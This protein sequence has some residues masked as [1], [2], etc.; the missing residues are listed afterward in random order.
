MDEDIWYIELL[1]R[2]TN[3]VEHSALDIGGEL[4]SQHLSRSSF[5]PFSGVR[6]FIFQLCSTIVILGL[7]LTCGAL[8]SYAGENPQTDSGAKFSRS[9]R[10]QALLI[11]VSKY[12]FKQDDPPDLHSLAD[13]EA[14]K[15]VLVSK[16]KFP[17]SDITILSKPNETKHQAILDAFKALIDKTQKGDIVYVHYSGHGSAWPDP[18]RRK[19]TALSQAIVPTDYDSKRLPDCNQITDLELNHFIRD[20]SKKQPELI[21]C[22]F[23]CCYAG[24]NTRSRFRC[25]GFPYVGAA[26]AVPANATTPPVTPAA[27]SVTA[28]TASAATPDAPIVASKLG[29]VVILYACRFNQRAW[30]TDGDHNEEMGIFSYGLSKALLASTP[31]TTYRDLLERVAEVMAERDNSGQI[32]QIEGKADNLIL[33][34]TAIPSDAA[35]EVT[36]TATGLTLAAGTLEGMSV[37]SKFSLFQPAAEDFSKPLAVAEIAQTSLSS[38]QLKI[39]QGNK[40]ECDKLQRLRALETQHQ[41]KGAALEVLVACKD[42]ATTDDVAQKLKTN[43][44]FDVVSGTSDDASAAHWQVKIEGET[45]KLTAVR[46]NGIQIFPPLTADSGSNQTFNNLKERLESEIRWRY[47][48][49]LENKNQNSSVSVKIRAVPVTVTGQNKQDQPVIEPAKVNDADSSSS[50]PAKWKKGDQ[51][52]LE[53]KNT[54]KKNA[55]INVIDLQDNG[56]LTVVYPQEEGLEETLAPSSHWT[57]IPTNSNPTVFSVNDPG[58]DVVKII[59]TSEKA[60]FKPL[61]SKSVQRSARSFTNP[62]EQLLILSSRTRSIGT[63][64]PPANW[65]TAT[66]T[67]DSREEEKLA[68][69]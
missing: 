2:Q 27:A 57:R 68:E 20:L 16:F 55:Y 18:S 35:Y 53:V 8:E 40:A 7:L 24:G 22:S 69:Q 26:D 48:S 32:P 29:N 56:D 31:K 62:L 21:T 6:S 19:L 61:E 42:A 66:I 4:Q 10:K 11:A 67:M 33:S 51:F 3:L 50:A 52:V 47:I 49:N 45:S 44:A 54:G 46:D 65:G 41:Y 43:E 9:G 23:D 15:S 14:I 5:S 63:S 34:G 58:L 39:T 59:A 28:V 60:N 64:V 1:S 25:R 36:R 30:E 37:G 17:N 12:H 38:S 13:V